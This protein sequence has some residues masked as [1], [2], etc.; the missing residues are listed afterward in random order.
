MSA[1][2]HVL[3]VLALENPHPWRAHRASVEECRP[4]PYRVGSVK[5]VVD[6]C[7]LRQGGFRKGCLVSDLEIDAGR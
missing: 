7:S 6:L 1:T 5:I 4:P 2:I 3:A